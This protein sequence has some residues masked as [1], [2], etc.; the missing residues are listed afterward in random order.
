MCPYWSTKHCAYPEVPILVYKALRSFLEVLVLVLQPTAL[1]V[2]VFIK[3]VALC[4]KAVRDLVTQRRA[5]RAIV[6]GGR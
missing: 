1:L 6:E 2:A 5:Q 3:K 4:V